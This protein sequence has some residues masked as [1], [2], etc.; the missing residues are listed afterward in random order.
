[1]LTRTPV[2]E[3]QEMRFGPIAPAAALGYPD[4]G[5]DADFARFSDR[6]LHTVARRLPFRTAQVKLDRP[7][8]SFSF[9]DFPASAHEVGAKILEDH[10]ARGTFYTATGLLGSSNPLWTVAGPDAVVDLHARG[11]E[12]GLHSHSHRPA[13]A[14]RAREFEADIAANRAALRRLVPGLVNETFAYPFGLS[15]LLQ[16]RRLGQ[17]ARASRS[18]QR[19]IN[20]GRMDLDFIRAYEITDRAVT[21]A[22]LEALLDRA[23]ASRAWLVF[24]TH[25]IADNPSRFGASPA[26]LRAV[27]H[28]AL[29]R[30]MAILPVRDAL[31]L[32]G[33]A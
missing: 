11:H 27:I 12:I 22:D 6:L 18:V 20:V 28:G 8:V 1:M 29:K 31:D 2:P 26:L 19:G 15:G 24:L 14:M 17:L 25:D 5:N 7:V 13:Y 3:H 10:G 23:A 30:D 33:V 21:A 9:D 32:I 16:K 4:S